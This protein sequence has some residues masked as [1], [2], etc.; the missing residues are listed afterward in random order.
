MHEDAE[1]AARHRSTSPRSSGMRSNATL[2]AA[3]AW[4]QGGGECRVSSRR[5]VNSVDA[6]VE[7]VDAP[8]GGDLDSAPAAGAR[9]PS[10]TSPRPA[11]CMQ[12]KTD[13]SAGGSER[14]VE[15][16]P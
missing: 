13:V 5:G 11:H 6:A 14:V 16:P 2:G 10:P 1:P 7:A 3:R 12:A 8:R 4:K 15:F 9:S